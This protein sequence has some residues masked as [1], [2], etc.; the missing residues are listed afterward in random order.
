MVQFTK[1]R[2]SGFKSFVDK[3]EM[4]I[5]PGL[6]G[7]VG[8]NGCGKSN[9][10]EALRWVM[11]ESSAKRMRSS[12]MNDVIFSGTDK[13]PAR[14]SAEVSLLLSNESKLTLPFFE[15][16]SDL[17]ITRK[18][19]RDQGSNYKING[20]NSRARDVQ[21]FFADISIG[22]N[23]PSMI[24]QG[25]VTALINAKP[26]ERRLVLEESAGIGGLQA[27]RHEA[28]L[29]L[30]SAESNLVRL[31]DTLG[32]MEMRL[33][34]LSR[35]IRQA[36]RYK[37]L[38]TQI[39]ENETLL[40]WLEWQEL[41]SKLQTVKQNFAL[42]ES[43]VQEHMVTVTQYTAKQAE[44]TSRIAPLREEE[45]TIAAALQRK[46]IERDRLSQEEVRIESMLRE[47]DQSIIDCQNDLTHE[48]A[49]VAHAKGR[50]ETITAS[51]RGYEKQEANS[52]TTLNKKQSDR[53]NLK[54]E[55]D[56]LEEILAAHTES[57]TK[58]QTHREGLER[59]IRDFESR[60][61]STSSRLEALMSKDRQ[62]EDNLQNPQEDIAVLIHDIAAQEHALET[63][64]AL[65]EKARIDLKE[66]QNHSYD[67]REKYISL[68][69]ENISL[70]S[71]IKVLES[72][73]NKEDQK[74]N[75]LSKID[76]SAGYEQALACALFDSDS[77]SLQADADFGWKRLTGT[78]SPSKLDG[79]S[80][81][82]DHVKAPNALD[83]LVS[84][85]LVVEKQEQGDALH[86]SLLPGQILVSKDGGF[87]RW[88][89][90]YKKA[91][92]QTPA[93]K[94]LEQRN[95]FKELQ[96]EFKTNIAKFAQAEEQN[97]AA[98][99]AVSI[100]EGALATAQ[101]NV[102]HAEQA[103]NE[104]KNAL[105]KSKLIQQSYERERIALQQSIDELQDDETSIEQSLMT[106]REQLKDA[107][108]QTDNTD[109]IVHTKADLEAKQVA[110]MAAHSAYERFIH[111]IEQIRQ[112]IA[113]LSDEKDQLETR[114]FSSDERMN[115]LNERQTSL[116]DKQ[117]KLMA[118]PTKIKADLDRLN[119]DISITE[120]QKKKASD[121]L[122][123]AEIDLVQINKTLKV[124]EHALAEAREER[125]AAHATFSALQDRATELA[126]DIH[127]QFSTAPDQ[128]RPPETIDQDNLPSVEH[129]KATR[130]KLL[131]SRDNIGPVNLAAEQEAEDVLSEH[132]ALKAEH[133][134]LIEAIA[135]LRSGISKLNKDARIRLLRAYDEVS[136]HFEI[137]FQRLFGGGTAQLKLVDADDPLTAGLEIY[138]QPPGKKLQSLS[139]LS[140]GEQ[141]L[142]SLA[143]IFSMFVVNPSPICIMDEVDAP[144]DDA[145]VDR[146]CTLMEE[147]AKDGLSRFVVITHHRMTM[148]RMNRLYGVTMGERGVSQLVSVNMA[149]ATQEEMFDNSQNAANSA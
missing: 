115:A 7:V 114:I 135:Q 149:R 42:I 138:A 100:C 121:N 145:N 1:L 131:R 17:E 33:S 46:I 50:L 99:T 96:S 63:N 122:S 82:K 53:D 123:V 13:R 70:S 19:Q 127:A 101:Q 56:N 47:V 107:E 129:I 36:K 23:S 18:I 140:G 22:A 118:S 110:F 67:K 95:R 41:S 26:A 11:G 87:W 14:Q 31:D 112:R 75:A 105:E 59:Q 55:L 30:K 93:A 20:K 124:S 25:K 40:A 16:V 62:M 48:T 21:T 9:L 45:T 116:T 44:E 73:L 6:T 71:E 142:T 79:T 34:Q 51:L 92:T 111:D 72:F 132:D 12:G 81:L 90:L 120:E 64:M 32:A 83:R 106:I 136:T 91:G 68:E 130:E 29:K 3:T 69:K 38:T 144:L 86:E 65:L 139:L 54:S 137:L 98:K 88:D 108:K 80:N 85:C 35:Q 58:A 128:L 8:P 28:E 37:G 126:D 2:L 76:V 103:L 94:R 5:G 104:K 78:S 27:R 143:L 133:T 102:K 49:Q 146:V 141:T 113:E 61:E 74:N 15:D 57:H 66:K 89:G 147:F 148:A 119:D 134:D 84:H 4:E 109:K 77:A 52:A 117:Q 10:V 43:L 24:S 125:A 60:L 39:E 97:E